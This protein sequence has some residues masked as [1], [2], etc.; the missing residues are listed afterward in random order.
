[1]RL[2]EK[3]FVLSSTASSNFIELFNNSVQCREQKHLAHRPNTTDVI[4]SCLSSLQ[5]M[6]EPK[7]PHKVYGQHATIL[8]H[9]RK[10]KK[11]VLNIHFTLLFLAYVALIST[12]LAF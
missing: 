9:V 5:Q 2:G 11:K 3:R 4:G 7:G 6:S 10:G 8:N 12:Y 1:M